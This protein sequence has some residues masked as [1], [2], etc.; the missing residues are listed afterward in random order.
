[1]GMY[2]IFFRL[3]DRRFFVSPINCDQSN[4]IADRSIAVSLIAG[5]A[6]SQWE[7]QKIAIRSKGNILR[8]I[9]KKAYFLPYGLL[10]GI[11]I[12]PVLLL[13][14]IFG[15]VCISYHRTY[16]MVPT[17]NGMVDTVCKY[18]IFDRNKIVDRIAV[19]LIAGIAVSLYNFDRNI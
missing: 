19:T 10:L 2:C 3:V 9:C 11:P 5:I 1:M 4:L 6:V 12:L 7:G 17:M 18:S 8:K 15:L 14:Y 13:P 16:S